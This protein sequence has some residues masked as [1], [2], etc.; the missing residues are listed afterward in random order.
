[1]EKLLAALSLPQ[2][3]DIRHIPAS[4]DPEHKVGLFA[5]EL[6]TR[7]YTLRAKSEDEAILWVKTLSH[8]REQ[9]L[10]NLRAADKD[11]AKREAMSVDADRSTWVKNQRWP[12][13][14]CCKNV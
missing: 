8:L 4:E 3:G 10:Q 14:C 2:V 11:A 9:G 7:V 6:N 1:M 5:I 12:V 13:W